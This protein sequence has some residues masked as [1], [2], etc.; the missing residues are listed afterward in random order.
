MR[1]D[2]HTHIGTM[3][4]IAQ[5][6]EWL[7]IAMERYQIDLIFVSSCDGVEVDEEMKKI[8]ITATNDQ[9]A[10]NQDVVDYVK[11]YPNK[12][13]ALFWCKPHYEGYKEEIEQ[14]YL[15]NREYIVGLKFHLYFSKLRMTDPRVLP[16]I[17]LAEKYHLPVLIHTAKETYSDVKYTYLLAKRFPQVNFIAAH[18][19]LET[20]D[21]LDAIRYIQKLPNLYGDTAWVNPTA[22]QNAIHTCGAHKILF[23]SDNPLDGVDTYQH[24]WYQDMFHAFVE[25][26][27]KETMEQIFCRNA[28]VLFPL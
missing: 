17:H 1:I 25:K 24:P 16:Y 13:R 3:P 22:L 15:Q 9:I 21:H 8:P 5:A 7:P 28:K 27:G 4:R 26:E 10:I 6:K 11:Q 18:M 14:F 2:I 12:M 23:G 19:Q 20:E